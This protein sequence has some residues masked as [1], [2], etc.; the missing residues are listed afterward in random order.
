[1]EKGTRDSVRPLRPVGIGKIWAV[2]GL[3]DP[4][5]RKI[6]YVGVSEDVW[7]RARSHA[8]KHSEGAAKRAWINDLIAAGLSYGVEILEP[9]HNSRAG[10]DAEARWIERGNA[11]GWPLVNGNRGGFAPESNKALQYWRLRLDRAADWAFRQR[12]AELGIS[13]ESLMEEVCERWAE[14]RAPKVRADPSP[15]SASRQA[16]SQ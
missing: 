3:T 8:G 10:A 5:D 2:Y 6:H 1:M 15:M 14:K 9:V 12:A 4:R 13:P 16:V 7:T 11:A